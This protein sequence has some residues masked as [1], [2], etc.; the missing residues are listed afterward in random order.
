MAEQAALERSVLSRILYHPDCFAQIEAEFT[1]D[2]FT[3]PTYK[4]IAGA[5]IALRKQNAC[6]D[7]LSVHT[8]VPKIQ[9]G[10]SSLVEL[11]GESSSS[12]DIVYPFTELIK[13]YQSKEAYITLETGA[14]QLV[15]GEAVEDVAESVHKKLGELNQLS[16]NKQEPVPFSELALDLLEKLHDQA[17]EP[18][19]IPGIHT[20]FPGLDDL[21]FGPKPGELWLIAARPSMGKTTLALNM[22]LNMAMEGKKIL[23][24][25]LE[26]HRDSMMRKVLSVMASIPL[27]AVTLARMD[28]KQ[29]A[30]AATAAGRIAELPCCLIDDT[31]VSA[32]DVQ[33]IAQK[34]KVKMGGLDGIYIDHIGL[35]KMPARKD[36]N[37]NYQ[38]GDCSRALK[39]YAMAEGIPVIALSQLNRAVDVRQDKRPMLSDLRDSGSLEQ[40]ADIVLFVYRDDYYNKGSTKKGETELI[41]SKQR[42]GPLGTVLLI[43]NA[44]MSR[45]EEKL[46]YN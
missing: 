26:M 15:E 16:K 23:F 2:L 11:A 29:W 37:R 40:D 9:G 8:K 44:A 6:L 43:F 4:A 18:E 42:N 46:T 14:E 30:R 45:F 27:T 41:V 33:R 34:A 1:T 13:R 21:T 19:G 24:I 39:A 17:L 32:L 38:V 22:A 7:I 10:I 35:M 36:D 31:N 5:F 20:G 25:S 12:W 28:A 3:E